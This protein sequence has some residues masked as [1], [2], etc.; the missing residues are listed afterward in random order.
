MKPLARQVAS[1]VLVVTAWAGAAGVASAQSAFFVERFMG[2]TL[3]AHLR[4]ADGA[5]QLDK[6]YV[7]RTGS[8][9]FWSANRHYITTARHDYLSSDWTYDVTFFSP[10]YAPDDILFIGMGEALPDPSYFNEPQNSINF[11]IHQGLFAFFTGW[12]V[13]VA[14]H[15]IGYGEFTYFDIAVGYLPPISPEG[16]VFTARIRKSGNQVTFEILDADP[17]IAV[18]IPDI[19]FTAPFLDASNSRIF[20]GNATGEYEFSD[21]R[22]L[23]AAVNTGQ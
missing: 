20:F 17:P 15:S 13:D 2:A 11:R 14:A 4:D 6:G 9:G 8:E 1:I 18:T 3:G 10:I 12:R 16:G 21:M 23:P 7:H 19:R 5:F 22:I